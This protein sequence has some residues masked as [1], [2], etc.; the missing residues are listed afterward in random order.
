MLNI[1]EINNTIA[2]LE[3]GN[4]TFDA[5]MKLSALYTVREHLNADDEVVDEYNDIPPQYREYASIKRKYQLGEVT[6]ASV[7][8]Q[9]KLVCKE[10]TEFI[11]TLYSSTDMPLEREMIK[12]MIIGLQNL[13]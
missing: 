5:C 7:E 12:G 2:E 10:I 9:T 13:Q 8:K 4:T 1:D 6:E 3:A 11:N